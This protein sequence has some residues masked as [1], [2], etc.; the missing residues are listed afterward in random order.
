MNGMLRRLGQPSRHP[1]ARNRPAR[2]PPTGRRG[3]LSMVEALISLSICSAL[4]VAT[5]AAF[6]ASAQAVQVND[7][8]FRASQTARVTVNQM[9][10]EVRRADSIQ[11]ST[12]DATYLDVIRPPETLTANEVYR[13]YKFDAANKRLTLQIF[14]TGNVAG[15]LY[16]L[17]RNIES[18]SFGPP[19]MGPDANNAVVVQRLPITV[20]VK[21]HKNAVSLTGAA[22]PRRATR[23]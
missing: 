5:G 23:Y 18:A 21:V 2:R 13:R 17:A 11:S 16:V 4:L 12:S 1:V 7:D 3:G 9:L 14:Y 10:V 6:T 8:F 15:P 20:N 22:S 19:Q